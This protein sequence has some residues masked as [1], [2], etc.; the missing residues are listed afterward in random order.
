M[1]SHMIFP[2]WVIVLVLT[3]CPEKGKL[4]WFT[5]MEC[6]LKPQASYATFVAAYLGYLSYDFVIRLKLFYKDKSKHNHEVIH[7]LV[8]FCGYA[9][10]SIAGFGMPGCGLLLTAIDLTS[11]FLAAKEIIPKDWETCTLVNKLTFFVAFTVVRI[12]GT[13]FLWYWCGFEVLAGW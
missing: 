10:S 6:R 1:I 9:T 2:T 5:D 13:P 8:A 4:G 7:H 3:S 12:I 11:I